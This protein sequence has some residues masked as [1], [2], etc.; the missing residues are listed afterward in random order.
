MYLAREAI[1]LLG[2][3]ARIL[4]FEGAKHGLRDREWMALRFLSRANRFSRT[5]SALASYVGTTRA[6]ASF[7]IGELERL[8]YIERKRSAMD[9]RSVLLSVTQQGKKFL[10]R[11]PISV[12]LEAIAVL[13]DEAKT[14]FRD[15]LR[16]ALDQA[17]AAEQRHHTDV[18]KRCIFLREDRTT[19]DSRT[20]AEFSCRLF[21]APIA[22]AEVDLLCTSF[23]HHRK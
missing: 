1:E 10:V 4:W 3:T 16:H 18:C 22:E 11:D 21:R 12:L 20:I 23:E 13:D 17:D 6:T 7:I 14:R 9:K 5:P 19:T 15:T 2:Q 8:G